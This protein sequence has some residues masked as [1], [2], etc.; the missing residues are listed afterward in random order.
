MKNHQKVENMTKTVNQ[1]LAANLKLVP[2]A[3]AAVWSELL[4]PPINTNAEGPELLQSQL[5]LGERCLKL[6]SRLETPGNFACDTAPYLE[7]LREIVTR[8]L[9]PLMEYDVRTR[10]PSWIN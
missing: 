8:L 6:G 4:Q 3:V 7:E 5:L 2:E 10:K 1:S 9:D